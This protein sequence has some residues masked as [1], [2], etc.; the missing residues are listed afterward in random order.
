[1]DNVHKQAEDMRNRLKNYIDQPG[2]DLARQLVREVE[3]LITEIKQQ[4]HPLTIEN[5][6]KEIIK[7]LEAFVD[8]TIMDYRHID[9]MIKHSNQMRDALRKL[10]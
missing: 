9:E 4:K 2:H 6:V 5:R 10:A 8:D 1:M 7:R 3:Q